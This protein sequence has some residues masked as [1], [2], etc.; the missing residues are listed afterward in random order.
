MADELST[1]RTETTNNSVLLVA[2]KGTASRPAD[3]AEISL[4]CCQRAETAAEATDRLRQVMARTIE[5]VK[6]LNLAGAKLQTSSLSL[7]TAFREIVSEVPPEDGD[8][9]PNAK[10]SYK[11]EQEHCGF[12][13]AC[14]VTVSQVSPDVVGLLIDMAARLGIT[15]ISSVDFDLR[16]PQSARDEALEQATRDARRR[17]TVAA[18]ALGLRITGISQIKL[19]SASMDDDFQSSHVRRRSMRL[20]PGY[21]PEASWIEPGEIT[22]DASV[23][24]RFTLGAA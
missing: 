24:I 11:K 19:G 13:A 15:T 1:A 9:H 10:P 4:A 2:G 23:T 6:A 21:D 8:A 7:R 14:T 5:A 17:A 16:D 12:D 3:T 22:E 18:A 20:M